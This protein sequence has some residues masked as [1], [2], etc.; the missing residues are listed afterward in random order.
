MFCWVD[1]LQITV[2]WITEITVTDSRLHGKK[3]FSNVIR[4]II[5]FR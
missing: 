4:K 5:H 1:Y 3:K 2:I